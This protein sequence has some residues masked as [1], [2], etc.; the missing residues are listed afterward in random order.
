LIVFAPRR[1]TIA[2][3]AVALLLDWTRV[4]AAESGAPKSRKFE[5]QYGA[6]IN[7]LAPGAKAR[8]WVPIAAGNHEQEVKVLQAKLPGEQRQTQERLYGNKT[9][10]CEATADSKG[11]I[12]I[13]VKYLVTR[14][15]LRAS[16]AEREN[17]RNRHLH[18]ASNRLVPVDGTLRKRLLGNETPSGE[19]KNVARRIYDAVDDLIKY[20]KPEG[21]AW[22]R[23]D[24]LWACDARY[25]NCTDFHAIFIGAC[26]DLDIP[27]KFE[28]GFPI[29]AKKGSGEVGG[30][31]C[32]AKFLDGNRWLPVD[33]SEADKVPSLKEYFFG[34]LTADRVSF[35]TGRDLQLEP[36]Q[37]S[38]P[39]NF[40][41]YPHVEVDGKIHAKFTKRFAYKDVE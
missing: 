31:H 24:A 14:R 21:K 33:I 20:D 35:T 12:A 40:L 1:L 2:L 4:K 39:V 37:Q 17:L 16:E 26:R 5:F 13:D 23:G 11:E 19:T 8:I 6:T 25:G 3:C 27:A 41:V 30:Y 29:P 34:N 36:P 9:Y 28:I 7:G 18:L 38:G 15:E 10:F 22:G 32:W